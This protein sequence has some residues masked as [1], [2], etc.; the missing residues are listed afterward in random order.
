[1]QLRIAKFISYILHPLLMPSFL[2]AIVFNSDS[3]IQL[4][5][6]LKLQ[7]AIYGLVF[8]ATFLLPLFCSLLLVK[9]GFIASLSMETKEERRFPFLICSILYF[10]T[11]YLLKQVH[12]ASLIYL[13]LLGATLALL[14][15]ML[16]NLNWKISAH[17]V[18]IGG[19]IGA[20][21]G[22]SLRLYIDYRLLLIC[23]VLLAGI[24]GTA[25]LLMKAHN[26]AQIYMGFT[27][28]VLSQLA[29]FL[30]L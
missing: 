9:L 23:L 28:G 19:V 10:L 3:Y 24:V 5:T 20:I 11:F 2:L 7:S 1:M 22:I 26:P 15:T 13:L 4:A 12:V 29:L 16:I 21:I 17:M 6:P 30:L 14:L 25:R 18:G 8:I 27:V